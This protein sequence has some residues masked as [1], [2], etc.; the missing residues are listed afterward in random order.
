MIVRL[1]LRN[2]T[3]HFVV[4]VGKQGWDYLTRDP[5]RSPEWGV[6]PLKELTSR[7]EALRFYRLLPPPT[8][9]IHEI[10]TLK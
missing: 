2:E 6:Y 7:I 4:I 10:A 8:V 9:S 3:T 1:T 5:A